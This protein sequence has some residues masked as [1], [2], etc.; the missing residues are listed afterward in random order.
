MKKA[1]VFFSGV[2]ENYFEIKKV[3]LNDYDI[4]CADGGAEHAK[5]L[6]LLP[7]LIIGDFDSIK[8]STKEYFINKTEFL[9]FSKDKDFTDGELLLKHIH[10]SYE[11]IYVLGAFGG[12][13]YHLLGNVFLLE[14]YPKV[15]LINDFE[16]V[17]Y[18][19]DT[20]IFSEKKDIKVSF[21]PIDKEN[22]ISLKG[23]K[24][25][26]SEKP[27]K[28]GDSLTLSNTITESIAVAEIHS[29]SFIAVVQ[30]IKEISVW[31]IKLDNKVSK[32]L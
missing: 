30:R 27:V 26:L 3:N 32:I 31:L 23:F 12:S 1:I 19:K 9:E 17:F 13:L 5:A 10:D 24:F 29:G 6:N 25:D 21:I 22:K 4:Y 20:Y 7:K 15:R 8:P 2:I 11:E 18:I 16:E 14:K 28:R